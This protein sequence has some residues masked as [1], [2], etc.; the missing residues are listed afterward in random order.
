MWSSTPSLHFSSTLF[1]SL[2][3]SLFF[4]H[5]LSHLL[6]STLSSSFIY[7]LIFSHL[8]FFLLF[9]FSFLSGQQNGEMFFVLSMGT[10]TH[11][12]THT[13][14][15]KLI[16]LWTYTLTYTLKYTHWYV[17]M[18]THWYIRLRTHIYTCI[19]ALSPLHFLPFVFAPLSSIHSFFFLHFSHLS[20]LFFTDSY[21]SPLF[22]SPCRPPH[23][24]PRV[25]PSTA[26][27]ECYP[28]TGKARFVQ[29]RHRE[30][31][32]WLIH[33]RSL[34]TSSTSLIT[35]MFNFKLTF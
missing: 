29:G 19:P 18:H 7:S 15:H 13:H 2:I 11:T 26:Q 21:I 16:C 23:S 8:L 14:T 10:Q 35:F 20:P 24:I 25:W 6:S 4:S 9:F 1:S 30:R 22:F 32:H 27:S 34:D 31:T 3:Y 5:L 12:H 17:Y 33:I 28:V